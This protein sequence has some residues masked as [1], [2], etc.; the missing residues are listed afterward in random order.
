M[1][2]R[3]VLQLAEYAG[4]TDQQ[5]LD[6]LLEVIETGRVTV[7]QSLAAAAKV[8]TDEEQELVSATLL[9]AAGQSAAMA[10]Y[11]A[12][13][14]GPGLDW[15]DSRF[16]S[17][18][19]LLAAAGSW[20]AET[21]AKLQGIGIQTAPRWQS[22]GSSITVEPTLESIA[23][24][25]ATIATDAVRQQLADRYNAVVAAIDAGEVATWDA[26]RAALGA[27]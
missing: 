18:L 4:L 3:D 25:R 11:R 23:A 24:A 12:L 26:V 6:R 9:A 27:E 19:D 8:L 7:Q 20:P 21:L 14:L 22:Y 16:Q 15:S 13:L 2:D 5:A 1:S 10:D 17:R